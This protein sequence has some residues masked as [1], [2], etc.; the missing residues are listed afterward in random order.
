[1]MDMDGM[2]L[3]L[4][5][6]LDILFCQSFAGRYRQVA[7]AASVMSGGSV[8]ALSDMVANLRC[9]FGLD[10]CRQQTA[11][12]KLLAQYEANLVARITQFGSR[13]LG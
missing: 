3:Y 11:A 6:C 7:A 12:L 2:T 9:L 10:S 5:D 1:M 13:Q 4:S 8:R